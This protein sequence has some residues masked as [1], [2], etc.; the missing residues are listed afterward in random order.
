[1]TVNGPVASVSLVVLLRTEEVAVEVRM[2]LPH[3][4]ATSIPH[5]WQTSTPNVPQTGRK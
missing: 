4:R 5:P 1:M 3:S 2:N